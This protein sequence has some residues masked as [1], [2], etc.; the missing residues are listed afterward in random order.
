[1]FMTTEEAASLMAAI[2]GPFWA[3]AG[4]A[5]CIREVLAID[6]AI[7]A[8]EDEPG[9]YDLIG[10]SSEGTTYTRVDLA[11]LEQLALISPRGKDIN[12]WLGGYVGR[13]IVTHDM[14]EIA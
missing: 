7:V 4:A 10:H 6:S 13:L 11:D 12:Y 8:R 1:M 2:H 9:I 14:G 3:Y 5:Q